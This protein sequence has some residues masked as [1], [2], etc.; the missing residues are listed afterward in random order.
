MRELL[1]FKKAPPKAVNIELFSMKTPFGDRFLLKDTDLILEAN[2]RQALFGANA[3]GKSLLFRNMNEVSTHTSSLRGR[4]IRR[5]QY[6]EGGAAHKP[7]SA[8]P[9]GRHETH[10]F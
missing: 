9:A 1:S 6:T 5:A 4:G 8:D 2:K 3:T 10:L 7:P